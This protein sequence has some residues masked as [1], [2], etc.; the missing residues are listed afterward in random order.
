MNLSQI[1]AT[2]FT[3]RDFCGSAADLSRTAGKLRGIGY[4]SVQLSR[5]DSVPPDEVVA[6]MAAHGL[7]ICSTHEPS[8]EILAQPGKCIEKL[9]RLGCTLTAYPFPKGVDLK[10]APAVQDLVQRLDAAGAAFRKAGMTLGYHNHDLEFATIDGVTILDFIYDHTKPEHLVG[11]LDTYWVKCGGGD[12][13]AWCRKLRGR[14]PFIHLKD[15]AL[16]Q[17]GTPIYCE[18]GRGQ[19]PFREIIAEAERSGCRWFIVEQ[20]TCPGDPFD[21]LA[22]S[23]DYMRAN[24]VS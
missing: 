9:R 2:L 7:T 17:D 24:L 20:D 18:I 13:V 12:C 10:Q 22:T 6:I 19:L 11:E 23:F 5:L 1:A 14:M 3:V 16:N 4:Q 21:S 8:D 15:Y